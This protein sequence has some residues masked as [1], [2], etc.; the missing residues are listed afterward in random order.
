MQVVDFVLTRFRTWYQEQGV[1]LD[2]IQ[3]VSSRRPTRPAD[4]AARIK[5]VQ[6][7][8]QLEAAESLA[9][10]NKR[11]ANILAKSDAL[12]DATL[13][14]A[15]LQ[16]AEEKALTTKLEALKAQ[17]APALECKDY[18]SILSTLA[19]LR[20]PVDAFFDNVMVNAEDPKVKANRLALL[21]DL[22]ALFLL[23]ADI[24]L[25]TK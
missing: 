19:A 18:T 4:F 15:L 12:E 24:S 17:I 13:D 9:A 14:H 16:L 11:V 6:A 21:A 20:E 5:A 23:T 1:D 25:L 7:F 22:R 3:S 10:A 2:V 8:K